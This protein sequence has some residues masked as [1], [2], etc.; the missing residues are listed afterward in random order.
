MASF[1]P[2]SALWLS[3]FIC[4]VLF[5]L[6]RLAFF[7]LRVP[8][9]DAESE[10]GH[11]LMAAGMALMLAPA[12]FLTAESMRW[13]IFLFTLVAL[14]FA[15]RLLARKPLLAF[16]S[17]SS[18]RSQWQA[19]AIHVLTSLG[20][21]CMFL[22][23]GN[24]ALS[25]TPLAIYLNCAFFSAFAYLLLSYTRDVSKDLQKT[26]RVDWLKLGADLAH[27]LMNGVMGWMF[28]EMIA[29]SMNMPRV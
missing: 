20:M 9:F 7:L 29:M 28:I 21:V 11:G 19:D 23:M 3:L 14:W 12:E 15:G 13:N 25:M 8:R 24:M 1:N 6:Y 18:E 17:G 4:I 22:E 16:L 2:F 5:Y 10:I 27:V 26:A